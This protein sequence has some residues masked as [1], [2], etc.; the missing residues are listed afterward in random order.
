MRLLE[1]LAQSNE[2]AL[3]EGSQVTQVSLDV[4][5]IEFVWDLTCMALFTTENPESFCGQVWAGRA[6]CGAAALA[7][8]LSASAVFREA[9]LISSGK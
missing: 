3:L 7:A 5:G 1:P 9:S 2:A 6:G 4:V 8:V